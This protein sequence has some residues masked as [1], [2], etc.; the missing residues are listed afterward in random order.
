[1]IERFSNP[2]PLIKILLT[3]RPRKLAYL[4][5]KVRC[6]AWYLRT[7]DGIFFLKT[8]VVDPVEEAATLQGIVNLAGAVGGQDNEGGTFG[9]HSAYFRNTNL[10]VRQHFKQKSLKLFVRAIHLIDEQHRGL[11]HTTLDRFE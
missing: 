6:N 10:K 11:R 2:W 8:R 1:P 7:H 9:L 5:C 4:T 3:H